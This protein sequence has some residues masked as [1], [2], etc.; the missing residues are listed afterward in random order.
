MAKIRKQY[1][2]DE[3]KLRPKQREVALALVEYEFD[4]RPQGEKMTKKEIADS[5]GMTR[6]GIYKWETQDKNF[7]AYKNSLAADFFD[8]Q[9]SFVYK[10]ML[11]GID[12][13]SMKGIELFLKRIGDLDRDDRLT[14]EQSG[15]SDDKTAA[16]RSAELLA[17]IKGEESE[18]EEETEED[19][20][21]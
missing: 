20:E 3:T 19:S 18:G 9:L 10:R 15:G 17:R 8:S 2:Y 6:Q 5:F 13:G 11:E 12:R 4:D 14:L 7:I 21:E 1:S 16:E